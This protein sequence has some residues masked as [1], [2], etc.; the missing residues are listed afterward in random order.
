MVP[1]AYAR[2]ISTRSRAFVT[3]ALRALCVMQCS[4]PVRPVRVGMV[5]ALIREMIMSA[6]AR[7]GTRAPDVRRWLIIVLVGRVRMEPLVSIPLVDM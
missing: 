2:L 6:R 5:C 7:L 1:M 4:M 3:L